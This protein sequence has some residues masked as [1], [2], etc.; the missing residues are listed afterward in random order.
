MFQDGNEHLLYN[1]EKF[2]KVSNY[3][4]VKRNP[5][6][7]TPNCKGVWIYGKSGIGKDFAIRSSLETIGVTYYEKD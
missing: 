2:V 4:R 6:R 3:V 1:C 7:S 5:P